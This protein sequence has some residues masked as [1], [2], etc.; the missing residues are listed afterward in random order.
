MLL[1]KILLSRNEQGNHQP[2]VEDDFKYEGN[3]QV[4]IVEFKNEAESIKVDNTWHLNRYNFE[5]STCETNCF[6]TH[7]IAWKLLAKSSYD[8]ALLVED[9]FNQELVEAEIN[10]SMIE[11]PEDWDVFFPYDNETSI[12]NK[13][14]QRYNLLNP[15]I[16]ESGIFEPYF[17]GYYWGSTIYFLS[18]KGA[19]NLLKINTIEQRVEDEILKQSFQGNIN[20]YIEDTKWFNSNQQTQY[21]IKEREEKIQKAIFESKAW[22]TSDKQL[23]RRI[24]KTLSEAAQALN[25][26]LLLQGGSLLGYVRLGK[27]LPWDDDVDIGIEEMS[28]ISFLDFVFKNT[29]LSYRFF[30]EEKTNV[31]YYKF[32][33][34]SGTPIPDYPYTFPFVDLWLYNVNGKDIIFKNGIICPNSASKEF[35]TVE[36]EGAIYKIPFNFIECLNTRYSTWKEYVRVYTYSH[37][38]EKSMFFPLRTK[39]KVN[40]NGRIIYPDLRNV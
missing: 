38:Y 21:V 4:E 30:I 19:V 37:K 35:K 14:K 26:D 1:Y 8:W 2:K 28:I 40:E 34:T 25:I 7:R 24:L 31:G 13:T 5:L 29:E 10:E 39:I 23:V 12:Y 9:N 16:Q 6:L 33:L 3:I 32:W 36:F 15:N 20:C 22:T 27:I 11:L 18:K 17:L